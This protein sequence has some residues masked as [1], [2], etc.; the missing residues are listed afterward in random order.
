MRPRLPSVPLRTRSAA[1]AFEITDRKS[2]PVFLPLE[3]TGRLIEIEQLDDRLRVLRRELQLRPTA[4]ERN[5]IG[6]PWV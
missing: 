1:R 5:L 2:W 4:A 3:V 6:G